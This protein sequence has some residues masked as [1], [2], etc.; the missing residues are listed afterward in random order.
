MDSLLYFI[1]DSTA[2]VASISL[3]CTRAST[4]KSFSL[5][6]FL[7]GNLLPVSEHTSVEPVWDECFVFSLGSKPKSLVMDFRYSF[8]GCPWWIAEEWYL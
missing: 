7:Q 2:L 4:N 8:S 3:E 5:C 1:A 6:I